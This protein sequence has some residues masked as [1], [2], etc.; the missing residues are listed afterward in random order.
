[1]VQIRSG[2]GA[3]ASRRTYLNA[4]FLATRWIPGTVYVLVLSLG[5]IGAGSSVLLAGIPLVLGCLALLWAC[6]RFERDL[7]AWWLGVDLPPMRPPRPEG[8][9]PPRGWQR[10]REH[11]G[12]SVTWKSMVYLALQL[13]MGFVA[14]VLLVVP[15]ALAVALI[16]APVFYLADVLTFRVL[17]GDLASPLL[18]MTGG[19]ARLDARGLLVSA[20]L[21]VV[22]VAALVVVLSLVNRAA[23]GWGSLA[24]SLLSA[25]DAEL[26]LG[27]ARR[28]AVDE[29]LRAERADRTRQELIVNLSHELRTPIASIRGHVEALRGAGEARPDPSTSERYLVVIARE[30]DR[31]STLVED[32]MSLARAE[33]DELRLDIRP[34]RVEEVVGQAERSVAAVAQRERQI[35]VVTALPAEPLPEVLADHDRLLQVL[36]N[37]VRNAVAYTP[38]GGLVSIQAS[39]LDAGR[40]AVQVADTG[41]GIESAALEHV[42]DRFYRADAS[43]SRQTGGFGLGLSIAK[44]LVDAMGGTITAES[45]PGRGSRFQVALRVAPEWH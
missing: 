34:V 5:L 43:R 11:A 42:F 35:K 28:V 10:L 41:V 24:R 25:S 30:S 12:L 3:L 36:L 4:L 1:M 18:W 15:L 45:R 7:A 39:R 22:G 6:A 27:E 23:A 29:H 21:C 31:L 37:L 38:E 26:Q 20:G 44:D 14:F 16:L 33:S 13:P 9:A 19:S 40:V 17:P 8:E 32:L 2:P